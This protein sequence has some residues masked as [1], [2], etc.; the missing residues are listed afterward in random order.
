MSS[1]WLGNWHLGS[2]LDWRPS[3][4]LASVVPQLVT[5]PLEHDGARYSTVDV[6]EEESCASLDLCLSDAPTE[7]FSGA[8]IDAAQ[9][10]SMPTSISRNRSVAAK[11]QSN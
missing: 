2:C 5:F 3:A 9:S 8:A 4:L 11:Q 1:R 6:F 7:V 10:R